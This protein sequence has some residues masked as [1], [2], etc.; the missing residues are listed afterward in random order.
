MMYADAPTCMEAGPKVCANMSYWEACR[1]EDLVAGWVSKADIE[2]IAS[3]LFLPNCS[4]R[5]SIATH[6]SITDAKAP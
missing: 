5:P 1:V 3:V 4:K 6:D 2:M